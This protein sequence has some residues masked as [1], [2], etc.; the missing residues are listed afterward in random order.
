MTQLAGCLS[1][2]KVKGRWFNSWSGHM[3]ELRVQSPAGACMKGSQSMFLSC[4]KATGSIPSQ[5]TSL[6]CRPGPWLGVCKRQPT[7]V[8]LTQQC[9]FLSLFLPPF[10]SLKI[11]KILKKEVKRKTVCYFYPS[12]CH[13]C[14]S[15]FIP[16]VPRFLPVS[17][18]FHPKNLL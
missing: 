13:F 6:G 4:R 17:F 2:S 5:G 11:N 1:F 3:S 15:S 14:Y 8:S 12:T 16:E 9:F 7:D 10:P 18:P